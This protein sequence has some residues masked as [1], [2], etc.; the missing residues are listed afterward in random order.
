[1]KGPPA[2]M[3]PPT[4]KRSTSNFS[5]DEMLRRAKWN[6]SK[7]KGD[8][9]SHSYSERPLA[10]LGIFVL[11]K[12]P[13]ERKFDS[14]AFLLSDEFSVSQIDANDVFGD[15]LNNIDTLVLPGGL[16]ADYESSLGKEG[17]KKICEFLYKGGCYYGVCAGAFYAGSCNYNL[18]EEDKKLVGVEIGFHPGLGEAKIQ[19]TQSGA[20]IFGCTNNSSWNL[21]FSNGCLFQTCASESYLDFTLQKAVVLAEY[22]H[23]NTNKM[24]LDFSDKEDLKHKYQKLKDEEVEHQTILSPS[25]AHAQHPQI[26]EFSTKP[27]AAVCGSY[28]QGRVLC[29]GPHPEGSGDNFALIIRN[30]FLWLSG[31]PVR[32]LA[33]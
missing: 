10:R 26:L 19:T 3:A 22:T 31:L 16:V 28:G 8:G 6:E 24:A 18:A 12:A 20:D 25:F 23:L 21:Y 1:M 13:H 4:V 7:R 14:F 2:S 9:M 33:V 27:A 11:E 32:P 17:R 29:F 15:G 30:C 5:S